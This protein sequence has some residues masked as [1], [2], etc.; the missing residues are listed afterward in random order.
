VLRREPAAMR[1][2]ATTLACDASNMTGIIDRLE[3][4]AL[5][6]REASPTDRRVKIVVITDEGARAVDAVRT[7]MRTTQTGLE[8]LSA[9]D[10]GTLFDLLERVFVKAPAT[11]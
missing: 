9:E 10:R 5:V 6:R 2:L 11:T 1:S 3:K 7:R 8:A 4:R